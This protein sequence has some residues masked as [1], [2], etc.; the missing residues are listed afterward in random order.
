[1]HAKHVQTIVV[2]ECAFEDGGGKIETEP[3]H[4]ENGRANHGQR[5]AMRAQRVGAKTLALANHDARHQTG[6]AGVDMNNRA[7]GKVHHTPVGEQCAVTAPGHVADGQI[8]KREPKD[9]EDQHGAEFHPF[10]ERSHNRTAS[11]AAGCAS[12]AGAP[13]QR[14]KPVNV[15]KSKVFMRLGVEVIM[16]AEKSTGAI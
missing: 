6:N 11:P 5:H 7:P 15:S 8:G 9:A 10:S 13:L 14:K 4:P 16:A 1:M 12:R 2:T 3:P